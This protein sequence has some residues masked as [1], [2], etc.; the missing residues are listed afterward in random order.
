[1]TTLSAAPRRVLVTGASKGIGRAIIRLFRTEGFT[2]LGTSRTPSGLADPI[3]GV[4]YLRLDLRD[5]ASI[6][7]LALRASPV[8]I[9]INNAGES[10]VWPAADT[11]L[12]KVRGLFEANLFG[13]VRLMQA[14]LPGMMERG[15]GLIINI[16]SMTGKFAVPFQSAYSASKYALAGYTWSLRN[17]VRDRGVEV[18]MLEPGH[19]RTSIAPEVYAAPGSPFRAPLDIVAATRARHVSK[20]SAPD[21]VARKA[22]KIARSR[23]PR[24]FY[25]SGGKAPLMVFARRL[26]SN[27]FVENLIRRIYGL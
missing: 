16:G 25:A 24:P 20:G 5:P 12:E 14:L 21:V 11:P 26:F 4:E 7:E 13:Q 3:E 17:E 1:M 8:D 10:Q 6:D 15:R 2:V 18:V 22:L 27:R 9:L 19:I 23:R